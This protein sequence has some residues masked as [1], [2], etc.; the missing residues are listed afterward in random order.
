MRAWRTR[1]TESELETLKPMA[2]ACYS[3]AQIARKLKRTVSA[4]YTRLQ[5]ERIALTRKNRFTAW[6]AS[7]RRQKVLR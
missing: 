5:F 3:A 2:N 6:K 1:W 7:T 4:V